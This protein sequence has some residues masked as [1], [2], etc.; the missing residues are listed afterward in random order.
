MVHE[1]KHLKPRLT[2]QNKIRHKL[3]KKKKVQA[4]LEMPV[5]RMAG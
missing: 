2:K 3:K 5:R 4:S 1:V